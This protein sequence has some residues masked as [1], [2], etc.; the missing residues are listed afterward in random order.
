MRSLS[1]SAIIEEL[2]AMHAMSMDNSTFL[3]EADEFLNTVCETDEEYSRITNRLRLDILD[4]ELFVSR[5]HCKCITNPRAFTSNNIES[6]DGLL[7]NEIFGYTQRERM[8]TFGYIDLHGWFIDPS[9]YKTWIRLDSRIQSIVHGTKYYRLDPNGELIEDEST[10]ETGIGFLK[11]NIDRI[12]FKESASSKKAM[13]IKYLEM[14]RNKMFIQKFI[15]IPP[16]YRDKNTSSGSRKAVGLSGLNKIYNNLIIY[17]NQLTATQDFGIDASDA[18]NG[19]VQETILVLYDWFCG[20]TNKKIENDR[21]A[22]GMSGKLGILRRT[23]MSKTSNFASRLVI[24][25]ADLKVDK[26]SDLMINFDKTAV[27]LYSVLAEFRDFVMFHVRTFFENEFTGSNTY[28]VMTKEGKMVSVIPD[29][30]EIEFSDERIKME[31]ERFLHGYN[32]RFIPIEVPVENS[33]ETYYMIYKGRNTDKLGEDSNNPIYN[34]RLT[35]CDIFYIS[36]VEATRD[37]QLLITRFPID[38]FSNQFTTGIVVS[39]T[40]E[41]EE[42]EFNGTVY[43]Y[44]P[45]IREED[46]GKDTSNSFIDTLRFSNLYLPGI[47]G[48]FDGDQCTCKG[49]YTREANDELRDLMNSKQNFIT[50]GC[51][52]LREPG[53]DSYQAIYALT[54]ILSTVN[55]TPSDKIE[56]K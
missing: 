23:N 40:K 12:K 22:Q 9:C 55:V 24:S 27:P 15:V 56:Y 53:S 30:P 31:M 13:S 54:K 17:T 46:I 44:Y 42:V 19:R 41:T 45:K 28:P 49:V 38:Y 7:S 20:N 5:N 25:P 52:P 4:V 18:M 1:D 32:N 43:K 21:N 6:P 8:G 48:D 14:N 11:K 26:P 2:K 47:G 10:G 39:S 51:A 36:A 3:M 35:W 33:K 50:F 37:K 34:R 16:F 29:S